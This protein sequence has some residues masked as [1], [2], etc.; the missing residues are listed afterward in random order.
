MGG[1]RAAG[2]DF[3]YP[4]ERLGLPETGS[5]SV[6][7]F[8]RRLLGFAVDA[9]VCDLVAL[10]LFGNV[11]WN[12][13]VFFVEIYLLT[14]L[15]GH[16]IGHRAL[17]MRVARLDGKPVGLVWALVRTVLLCLLIPALIWDRDSRGLHDKAANTVIVRM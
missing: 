2:E 16:S 11:A 13:V 5:G 12:I 17:G 8:G 15:T 4:G 14:A 3:G 7:G 10:A 6:A 9:V 1:P